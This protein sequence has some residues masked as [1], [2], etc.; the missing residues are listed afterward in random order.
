MVSR[1]FVL[2]D[3]CIP[4]PTGVGFNNRLNDIVSVVEPSNLLLADVEFCPPCDSDSSTNHDTSTSIAVVQSWL[5]AENVP[6][7]MP[8]PLP[9][10]I[11]IEKEISARLKI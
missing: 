6:R 9:L 3:E 5:Q 10:I 4:M 11:K 7:L 2:K 8:N 1:I